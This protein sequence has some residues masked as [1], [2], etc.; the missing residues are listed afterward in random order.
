[1]NEL[2]ERYKKLNIDGSYIGLEKCDENGG[3]FLHPCERKGDWSGQRNP[4]L[5]Y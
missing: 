1:M 4:L 2:Y 5:L 3:L